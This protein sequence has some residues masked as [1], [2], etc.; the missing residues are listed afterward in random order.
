MKKIIIA[1][2]ADHRGFAMKE[3]LKKERLMTGYDLSWID[4]GAHS[5][6]R[7]DYP[8]FAIQVAEQIVYNKAHLGVLLCGTG[9]GMAI[10]ANRFSGVYAGLVWNEQVARRA[11]EDDTVNVLVLPSDYIDNQK[12]QAMLVAWLGAKFKHE[13]YSKRIAMIDAI[14]QQQ[15]SE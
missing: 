7:S 14:T 13:R 3:Y 1:I 5:K 15:A 2:G 8:L 11:K 10:A 4:V 12:A 9:I 6:E